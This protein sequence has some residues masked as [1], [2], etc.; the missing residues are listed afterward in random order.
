MLSLLCVN[1]VEAG[2]R[3]TRGLVVGGGV[4]EHHPRHAP[5]EIVPVTRIGITTL[6]VN[7][8]GH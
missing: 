1:R 7:T 3:R 5:A 2:L 8:G 4:L 6:S